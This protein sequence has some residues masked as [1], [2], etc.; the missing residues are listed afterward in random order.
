MAREEVNEG[1]RNRRESKRKRKQ[2]SLLS[3]AN[4][5]T[6]CEW[7]AKQGSRGKPGAPSPLKFLSSLNATQSSSHLISSTAL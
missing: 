6:S 3:S 2:Q 7:G 4:K 5:K 1:K